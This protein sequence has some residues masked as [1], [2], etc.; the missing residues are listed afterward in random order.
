MCQNGHPEGPG[1]RYR[2]GECRRCVADRKSAHRSKRHRE[3]EWMI[4]K[5]ESMG[6]SLADID[7]E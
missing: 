3:R 6:L 7:P 4:T 2:W 5:L 1:T